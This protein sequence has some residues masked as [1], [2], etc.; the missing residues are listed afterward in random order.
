MFTSLQIENFRA[1]DR[2]QVGDLAR[3]NLIAG[4]NNTGK[5]AFLEA[6]FLLLGEGNPMLLAT[7]HIHRGYNEFRGPTDDVLRWLISPLFHNFDE[8]A[9]VTIRGRLSDGSNEETTLRVARAESSQIVFEEPA[10]LD[11]TTDRG[12]I[13]PRGNT[14]LRSRFSRNDRTEHDCYLSALTKGF[15][16]DP[17]PSLPRAPGH[18]L[19]VQS[20][21]HDED[22]RHFGKLELE[23]EPRKLLEWLRVLEPRLRRIRAIMTAGG[24][25]LHADIGQQRMLPIGLC[26]DGFSRLTSILLKIATARSGVVLI[27]EIENGIH[28]SVM[29]RVWSAIGQAAKEYNV[30]LFATTHSWECIEAAHEAFAKEEPYP[31]RMHRF[32]RIDDRIDVVTY[33][34]ETME[35]ALYHGLELR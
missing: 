11:T 22:A 25:L 3:I 31:F 16:V 20:R 24:T 18:F 8:S 35:T 13:D 27:D 19:A 29:S 28:Y 14:R 9:V 12:L 33:N 7:A 26:G 1:F 15:R 21:P 23:Q 2:L 6:V 17:A 5:T 32:D 10:S 4:A 30:Q 34:R